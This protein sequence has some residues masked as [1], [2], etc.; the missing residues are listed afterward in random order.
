M[1]QLSAGTGS[2]GRAHHREPATEE[3]LRRIITA[4]AGPEAEPRPDQAQAVYE[5]VEGRRRVL[6]VQATGWGKSAVYWAATAALREQ[7]AGPTLV[8]SPLL[9]LMRDQIAAAARAGLQRGDDQ[10]DQRRRVAVGPG[11]RPGRSDRCAA[12]LARTARQSLLRGPVARPAQLVRAAGHRRGPL[13]LRLGLR[14]PPRLS[15]T[16]P[17]AARAGARHARA[18]HHRH[19]QRAG[20]RRRRRP[21]GGRHGDPAGFAGPIVAPPG[22]G[23]GAVAPRALRLGCRRRPGAARIGDRLRA[24]RGRDRAGRRFPQ[25]CRPRRSG[26]LRSDREPRGAG[27]PAAR[28]PD[29][30]AGRYVG[31]GDGVRQAGSR[32]LHPPRLARVAGGLLP[33]GRPG[34]PRPGRCVGRAGAGRV[35]RR[36]LE[37]LRHRRHPRRGPGRAGPRSPPRR[38]AE[39]CP[40]SSRRP[41]SGA[42]DSKVC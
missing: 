13:R 4:M 15:A 27:G 7:G 37:L 3:T 35:R 39:S 25:Q 22:G 9:A 29:Q 8:V 33:A 6:V 40:A 28:Q 1:R 21:T 31:P 10:L 24:D 23:A 16:D 5:L 36:D 30:G 12:H 14:F 20:H 26:L 38:S 34:R 32:L 41:A 18:G 17:D 2:M 42:P 11:R 19:R